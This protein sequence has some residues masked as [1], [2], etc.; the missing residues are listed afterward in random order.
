MDVSL[1]VVPFADVERPAIGVS[2]LSAEVARLGF[3]CQLHYLNFDFAET[4]GRRLYTDI[5]ESL[6]AESLVG[7]WFFADKVFGDEIPQ[8]ELYLQ[9]VLARLAQPSLIAQIMQARAERD[10]FLDRSVQH[11]MAAKPRIVGF[12]TTFHQTCVSLALARRLKALPDPP[13]VV[14]GGANCEGEMGL[15]MLRSFEWLDFVC[16]REGDLAFPL[17]V[18]RLMAGEDCSAIPGMLA[19]GHAEGLSTPELI[20]HLDDLPDPDYS[21]YF[22]RISRC[23]PGFDL[24]PELLVETARGCWWGMKNHCTFCGLNGD[25]MSYRSKSPDRAFEEMRRLSQRW[26]V[27]KMDSVDN[28][29]DMRYFDTVFP[30]LAELKPPLELFFEVKANLKRSQVAALRAAGVRTIQPGIESLATDVLQLMDKGCTALQNLQLLRW[31]AEHGIAVAWNLL[32]GFPGEAPESYARQAEL[33]PKLVH[34]QPPSSCSPIRLD[35]FS[36]LYTRAAEF[37]LQRV[38]PTAA[39]FH[40][41]PLGRR[42]MARLASFFDFDHADGR[43]PERY[44]Q[45]TQQAVERWIALHGAE[46]AAKPVFEA[47]QDGEVCTSSTPAPGP[48]WPRPG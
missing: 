25:T 29:L 5:S 39:Y 36:P 41:F 9:R 14:F 23:A 42:D 16:T 27:T 43:K 32:A 1:V 35:R 4:I 18:Q 6:P 3:A 28:I 40:V 47:T 46:G 20:E 22:A 44:L 45:A 17:L 12:S 37:G 8:P 11:I 26:G 13:V 34:L 31:C 2:L 15:Q 24:A 21:D 19:Q 38:R 48:G 30:R 7:E 10:A 33:C